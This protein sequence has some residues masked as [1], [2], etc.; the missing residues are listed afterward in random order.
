MTSRRRWM[1][2]VS[3]RS[4]ICFCSLLPCLCPKCVFYRLVAHLGILQSSHC[5]EA[6]RLC[7]HVPSGL[8][9]AGLLPVFELLQAH[10]SS[11]IVAALSIAFRLHL[12]TSIAVQS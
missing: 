7:E 9:L 3:V 11:P 5:C 10:R 12:F 8:M 6:M 4:F 2:L 1:T